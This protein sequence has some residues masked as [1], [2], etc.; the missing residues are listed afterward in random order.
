MIVVAKTEIIEKVIDDNE[1]AREMYLMLVN[2]GYEEDIEKLCYYEITGQRAANLYF[3]TQ[4]N[5]SL[6]HQTI[7]FIESGLVSLKQIHKNLDSRKPK[8]IID[9][10]INDDESYSDFFNKQFEKHWKIKKR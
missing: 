8:P 2:S 7:M 4:G 6:T 1:Y 5:P 10:V 9:R 3:L